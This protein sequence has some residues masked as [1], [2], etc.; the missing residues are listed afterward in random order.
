MGTEDP[1][2]RTA[3]EALTRLIRAADAVTRFLE[4]TFGPFG[5]T[6]PQ[7]NVLRILRGAGEPL[8]TMEVAERMLQKTPGVTG[9]LDRL[10]AKGLVRRERS[11][12]DRRV[13]L[14]SITDAGVALLE[15]MEGPVLR[16][17]QEALKGATEPELRR[18]TELLA[19]VEGPF[20]PPE[21]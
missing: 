10:Q 16:A 15:E 5:V 21:E 9:L 19:R 18:L 17:N 12:R 20:K 11:S 3:A 2:E 1:T 6:G 4:G 7:Y 8:P 13:W 14:C